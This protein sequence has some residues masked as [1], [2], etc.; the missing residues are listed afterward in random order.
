MD[1]NARRL[2]TDLANRYGRS[3]CA[4]AYRVL[5]NIHDAEDVLQQVFLKLLGVGNGKVPHSPL[6]KGTGSEPFDVDAVKDGSREVPVPL[7]QR[8]AN[9]VQDWDA[10]L[11]TMASRMALDLLRAKR[12]RW[13]REMP[14]AGDVAAA[15]Q[16][17]ETAPNREK[18]DRLRQAVAALP[19]RDAW[20]FGLRYFE[21]FSYESIAA[22]T[23]LSVDLIGV[24]LHRSRKTLREAVELLELQERSNQP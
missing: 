8:A 18:L 13:R 14:L 3:V 5:G 24:I 17:A 20:V 16:S 2:V 11:R 22:Q 19:E 7:F 21:E 23:G 12:S 6:K 4:A 15:W 10:Y 9:P 1:D